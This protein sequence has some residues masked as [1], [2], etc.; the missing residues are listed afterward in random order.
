MTP[1]KP[2]R[3]AGAIEAR[4]VGQVFRTSTQDVIALED[5]SIDVKP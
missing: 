5:V 4:G 3:R 2:A 1:L